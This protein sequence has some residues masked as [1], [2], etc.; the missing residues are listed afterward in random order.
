MSRQRFL[1][2]LVAAVIA[3]GGALYLSAQRNQQRETI[4]VALLP[5]LAGEIIRVQ[6]T[7]AA[8]L[9][10]PGRQQ[11]EAQQQFLKNHDTRTSVI[12]SAQ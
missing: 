10:G 11:I 2:L 3:I 7:P 6:P 1:A 4:G 5:A 12:Q 9:A 8:Q